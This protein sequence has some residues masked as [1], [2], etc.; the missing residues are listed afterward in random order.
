MIIDSFEG[1]YRFLS[2]FYPVTLNFG[3]ISFPTA[4]HAYQAAKSTD[5]NDWIAISHIVSPGKAKRAGQKLKLRPDWRFFRLHIMEEIVRRKFMN[6]KLRNL[7]IST[8][9]AELI[10]GNN[11]DDT[12][13]GVCD[14]IGENHLGKIL[15]KIRKE[16]L[17]LTE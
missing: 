12:F 9:D 14:G 2:N 10:E 8:D 16:I 15:M 4:E 13:W 7:L 6:K 17:H 11:W 1:K 5:L 3:G